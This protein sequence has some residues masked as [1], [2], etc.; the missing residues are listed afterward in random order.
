MS[1]EKKP[2]AEPD[3]M[4]KLV[5]LC[6]R[7]GF[8]FQS[9]EIYGGLKSCYDY[10]PLG[11][12]LKRNVKAEW[13]RR[14]VHEREDVVGL[15]ASIIMSP[16]VWKASGHLAGFSDPVVDCKICKERFRA[17]KAPKMN[18]GALDS[19]REFTIEITAPDKGI[20]K[21]WQ[22]SKGVPAESITRFK[23]DGRVLSAKVAVRR[24]VTGKSELAIADPASGNVET[25]TWH[26]C[27]DYRCPVCGSPFLSDERQFNL[28]FRA[29]L[30]PVDPIQNIQRAVEELAK[31]GGPEA[32][33]DPAKL[34]AAIAEAV[35]KTAV[36]LR[37]ETAQAMFVNFLN[38]QT[39]ARMK[40]PFG[41][42]QQGKSFRNE[43]T[44]EHFIFRS[45]EFEQM[46]M[47]FFV[48][49]PGY[50]AEGEKDDM[51]WFEYWCQ[52]R[53][54]W[55]AS[56]GIREENLRL[57]PHEASELAHYAKACQDVE[58]NYPWGWGNLK[59]S[60]TAPI[61]T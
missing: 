26:P 11:A 1:Q 46:E 49:P 24:S 34:K 8:V 37:P 40:P 21:V 6:K 50:V 51:A 41:I 58:Y 27:N 32:L 18:V 19:P 29:S 10:G 52:E 3:V 30:G 57:R 20:A 39:S 33:S 38:V 45:C 9:S 15:D 43:I 48:P 7:R 53:R 60:R 54:N 61:T 13:W 47:E 28:M 59:G 14:M 5:S 35:E 36:Y 55:Y 25:A 42:A 12:E 22:E 4:E 31:S 17:D 23:R 56:L 16:Q 44:V 2:A